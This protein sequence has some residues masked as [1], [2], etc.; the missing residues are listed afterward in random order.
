MSF[1]RYDEHG[2]RTS[3]HTHCGIGARHAMHCA[4]GDGIIAHNTEGKKHLKTQLCL[5]KMCLAEQD[6]YM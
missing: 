5:S 6:V 4:T 2:A 3:H 1:L